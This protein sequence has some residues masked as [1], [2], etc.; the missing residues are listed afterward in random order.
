MASVARKKPGPG[1]YDIDYE[2]GRGWFLIGPDG[3]AGEQ[4][5]ANRIA[6]L[7]AKGHA[8]RKTAA[9]SGSRERSC[10]TCCKPFMSQGAHHRMCGH[11]RHLRPDA[12]GPSQ[13]PQIQGG[14]K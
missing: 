2:R 5:F 11:C 13:T 7:A 12:L 9:L 4:R 1:E 6:A 3:S 10:M 14:R 8:V